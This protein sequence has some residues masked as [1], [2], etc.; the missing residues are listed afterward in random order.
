MSLKNI[1][2]G[3]YADALFTLAK[4]KKSIDKV[5]K[6]LIAIKELIEGSEEFSRMLQSPIVNKGDMNKAVAKILDKVKVEKITKDFCGV[7]GEH[8]RFSLLPQIISAFEEC[9]RVERGVVEA[10][11][12]SASKLKKESVTKITKELN[13]ATGKKVELTEKVDPKI[14]GGLVIKMGSQMVDDSV[15]GKLERLRILQK[16]TSA[17]AA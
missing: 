3:R 7:V 8:R 12:I 10:E 9:L 13:K 6:D 5:E 14:L 16:D 1:L 11:I 17:N 4:E 2:S 15:N